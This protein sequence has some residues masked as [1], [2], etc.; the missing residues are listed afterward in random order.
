MKRRILLVD[1]DVAILL[2]LKAVLEINGFDVETAAAARVATQRLKVN[3]YHMVITDLRME[4]E[5]AGEEVATAAKKAANRPA[6]AMLTA[7]PPKD[8]EWVTTS[9]TD[10][11]LVKP[12]NTQDLLRQ[13]E[14]MLVSHEDKKRKESKLAAVPVATAAKKPRKLADAL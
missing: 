10:K 1:D 3:E 14:A 12:M 11:V 13:I 2:T 8:A 7:Y 6:V 9:D 5:T 4:S